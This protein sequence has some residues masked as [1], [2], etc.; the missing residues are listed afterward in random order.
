MTIMINEICVRAAAAAVQFETI[1]MRFPD[2]CLKC[3]EYAHHWLIDD[4][5]MCASE[6]AHNAQQQQQ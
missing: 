5:G 4:D 6:T 3:A 2:V 1:R